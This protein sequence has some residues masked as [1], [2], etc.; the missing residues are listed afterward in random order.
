VTGAGGGSG[1]APPGYTLVAP[2][3]PA[4]AGGDPAGADEG[5]ALVLIADDVPA[6]VELLADQL[7]LLGYRTVAAEDGPGALAAAFAHAPDLCLL[8]VTMPAGDLGVPDRAAGF[9][10]CRR[11]KRD[12]RTARVPV[13]FVTALNDTADRVRAIEAGGD[14]FLTKP[15]NRLVLGARV[16]S[17]IRLKRATDALADSVRKLRELEKVR[18][19]LLNMLVHDLKSPLA[20]VL[21][22]LEMA[23]DGD[24]GPVDPRARDALA[25]A[26]RR[27]EDLLA[28]IDDL[29]EVARL[30]EG[31]LALRPE[32]LAPAELL[33]ELARDW[34]VRFASAGVRAAVEAAPGTPGFV[35]DRA[36]LRR[37][38]NNLL[39]NALTH[40]APPRGAA[41]AGAAAPFVVRVVA[42]AAGEGGVL[43]TVADNGPGVPSEYQEL[44][45]RKFETVKLTG[46]LRPRG[47]G[48]GLA[49]CRMVVEAHGGRVWVQSAPGHGAAF[50]VLLPPV[51]VVEVR[52]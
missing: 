29:L 48:L 34:E 19:D 43:F 8:D 47:S 17:L 31:R 45:F 9:E 4:R 2:T 13:I 20:G 50:H 46:A 40:A 25:Q 33:A 41:G 36:L 37:V 6:N 30:E 1:G 23:G 38:F 44:I 18:D 14:D 42:R 35:G 11:L 12:P 22:T 49:F 24:F 15:H 3:G 5:A 28:L 32:P 27:G 26:H 51:P 52:G 39:E 16:R 21:A 7:Q 10:V